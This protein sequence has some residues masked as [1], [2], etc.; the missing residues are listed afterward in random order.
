MAAVRCRTGAST[1]ESEL[2]AWAAERL[3]DY[4]TPRRVVF[5]DALPRTGT[6]KVRKADVVRLFAT[7]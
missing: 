7:Q 2:L 3:A 4:K 6:E 1:S 5:M